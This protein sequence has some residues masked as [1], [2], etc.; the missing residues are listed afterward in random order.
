MTEG[1]IY[2]VKMCDLKKN[3]IYKIYK[4]I[5]F[6]KTLNNNLNNNL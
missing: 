4:S 6:N 1:H 5:N 2:L 3:T